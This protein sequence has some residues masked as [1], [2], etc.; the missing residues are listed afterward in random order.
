MGIINLLSAETA[1]MIAA[2]EVVDRPASALKELIEN[3][4]DAGATRISVEIR[5]G[6]TAMLRVID[7][8]SG[9]SRD[10]LP[11]TILRHATSKIRTG[12]DLDGVLTLG[13][14]GEAL[15]AL[16]SVS[17]LT[18][19]TRRRE[20]P[21]GTCLVS[22]ENGVELRPCASP[23]GTAVCA[24]SLFYNQPARRKFM[25]K[26]VTECAACVSAAEKEALSHPEIAF[27]VTADGEKRFN[28]S[29]DGDPASAVYAVYGREFA[30]SLIPVSGSSDGI[31]VSG[32]V[33]RP[34]FPAGSRRKQVFFVN[35]RL[36]QN[37]TLTAALERGFE[38][39]IPRGKFPSAVLYITVDP[40]SVDVNV[41]PAKLEIKFSDERR[42]FEAVYCAVRGALTAPVSSPVS[43]RKSFSAPAAAYRM[44]EYVFESEENAPLP[45]SEVILR[46]GITVPERTDTVPPPSEPAPEEPVSAGPKPAAPAFSPRAAVNMTVPGSEKPEF[47]YAGSLWNTYVL[48][49]TADSLLIIDKHAAHE[50]LIYERMRRGREGNSQELI[51]GIPVTV[52]TAEAAAAE[53]GNELLREYGYVCESFGSDTV[54]LR[55]VPSA[56]A[57]TEQE[58]ALFVALCEALA[59]GSAVP[60]TERCDRAVY[61]AACKAAVKANT[62]AGR[63]EDEALVSELLSNPGARYCPHGRPVIHEIKKTGIDRFF[64]R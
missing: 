44:P 21:E 25:K 63:E 54:I 42:V 49:E 33:S 12:S 20:D 57:G 23:D 52:G 24:E 28:T 45:L 1:N 9:I 11:K 8:G 59:E 30:S 22:D 56:V 41:H 26:D 46:S 58:T 47:R 14:R 34:D 60:L 29:G 48:A 16:S 43:E 39:Y 13:F 7:N 36:V 6:G 10:D 5:G 55:A 62:P 31:T 27:T 3:S 50:R 2:G 18:I 40:L 4:V 51:T 37:K 35:R 64:D 19:T 32:F 38:S 15:A 53:S 17:R 61:T